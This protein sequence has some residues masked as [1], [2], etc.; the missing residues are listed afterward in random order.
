[1]MGEKLKDVRKQSYC[2]K[3]F[4]FIIG[5]C[6]HFQ[7]FKVHNNMNAKNVIEKLQRVAKEK[8]A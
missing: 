5:S 3:L 7:S 2:Q 4:L 1:M 6:E 8:E